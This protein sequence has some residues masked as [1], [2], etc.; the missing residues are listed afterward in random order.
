[1]KTTINLSK[2]TYWFKGTVALFTSLLF[3]V[4]ASCEKNGSNQD[5]LLS[6]AKSV[7]KPTENV[8]SKQN[9]KDIDGNVY[10]TVKI[11]EQWWMAE[12]L[13]TTRYRDGSSIPNVEENTDWEALDPWANND[14]YCWYDNIKRPYK[15]VYGALYNMVA[16]HFGEVCPTGW[17]IPDTEELITLLKVLDP[18][19]HIPS[20]GLV[21]DIAGGGLKKTG[22]SKWD[23]LSP[24]TGA[25]NESGFTALPGGYR[26][27]DG[28]FMR[29]GEFGSW[30]LDQG[31][32]H[33]SIFYDGT[34]VHWSE[35]GNQTGR[36]V[37][38]MMD[39]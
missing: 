9:V 5:N 1:M 38:C 13:K 23:W 37:R 12:N 24:N 27:S 7:T 21:S 35:G 4:L 25:T 34:A 36:S 32:A 11:G 39:N 2:R 31:L 22:T 10:K 20:V 8:K 28:S 16:V 3:L 19:A 29:I 30:W 17:H 14:A 6:A 26:T 15:N 18:D 33:F